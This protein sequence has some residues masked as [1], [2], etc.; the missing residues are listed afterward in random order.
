MP[1]GATLQGEFPDWFL[2]K[3]G[4]VSTTEEVQKELKED[5]EQET[6]ITAGF[7]KIADQV[8]NLKNSVMQKSEKAETHLSTFVREHFPGF[9]NF[10]DL[11]LALKAFSFPNQSDRLNDMIKRFTE[12]KNLVSSPEPLALY[13]EKKLREVRIVNSSQEKIDNNF[14]NLFTDAIDHIKI[15]GHASSPTKFQ[16]LKENNKKAFNALNYEIKPFL[17]LLSSDELSFLKDLLN[18]SCDMPIESFI[19]DIASLVSSRFEN[20]Q[21]EDMSKHQLG[22]VHYLRNFTASFLKNHAPWAYE[23]IQHALTDDKE[24][25]DTQQIPS[26]NLRKEID[27]ETTLLA[28]GNLKGWNV[29]YS[30]NKTTDP[31]SL[32]NIQ[33]ESLEEREDYL[34]QFFLQEG[35]STGIKPG[36]IIRA[37]EWVVGVPEETEQLRMTQQIGE[38]TFKKLKRGNLRIFYI[39]DSDHKAIIFST[40]QKK[41][42]SYRF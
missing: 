5:K 7:Q 41:A 22:A 14:I 37:L 11:I 28:Q 3:N 19:W 16:G 36:S 31:D 35:I 24:A 9:Q 6:I 42:W 15:Q 40:Y 34:R 21:I 27:D 39:V 30:Q 29:F 18:E 8:G 17:E 13:M 25:R 4:V 38:K 10:A 12:N 2:E 33:G 20:N 1:Y 32:T 23:Q 26:D